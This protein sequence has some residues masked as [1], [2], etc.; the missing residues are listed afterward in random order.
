MTPPD[1]TRRIMI[2]GGS[3]LIGRHLA[4]ALLAQRGRRVAPLE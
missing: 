2:A 4:A 1:P 3:G